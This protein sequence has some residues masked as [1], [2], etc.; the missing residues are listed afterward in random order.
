MEGSLPAGLIVTALGASYLAFSIV[1]WRGLLPR[2]G[3]PDAI[4]QRA[5]LLAPVAAGFTLVGIALA[6]LGLDAPFAEHLLVT[7]FVA[8]LVLGLVGIVLFIASPQRFR[9]AWQRRQLEAIASRSGPVDPTG[10]YAVE[11]IIDGQPHRTPDR[12][13]TAGQARQAAEAALRLDSEAAYA[14]I[15]DVTAEVSI[16]VVERG[17]VN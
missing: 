7:A 4:T 2:R 6:L 9:P 15:N 5:Y 1:Q 8:F 11:L 13:P 3:D 16:Q 14:T 17:G 12:Y 10:P